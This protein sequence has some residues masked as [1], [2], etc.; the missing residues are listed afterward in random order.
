MKLIRIKELFITQFRIVTSHKFGIFGTAIILFFCLV[1][2]LA[3]LIAPHLP[4]DT[5]RDASGKLAIMRTPCP[6]FPMGTTAMGRDILSQMLYATRTTVLIGLVSGLISIVIGA[7]LGLLSGYYGGKVDEILMR[8]TDII[9]G[10]PFLPFLIVVYCSS[11]FFIFYPKTDS[12]SIEQQ[13]Y[14]SQNYF[15]KNRLY[16]R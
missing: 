16:S 6:E 9:Y 5:I 10:I 12:K 4:W 3:P 2:L 11:I 13:N 15:W 7:N 8:L 1:G 14:D